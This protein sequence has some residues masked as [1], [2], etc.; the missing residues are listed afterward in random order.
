MET[1]QHE[2]QS[3]S[4]EHAGK[5]LTFKVAAEFYGIEILKVRE[6]IGIIRIT[7]VPRMPDYVKGVINLRGK[8]IPIIDLRLRFGLKPMEYTKRTCIVVV[9]VM[10]ENA[11]FQVGVIVDEVDEVL[12]FMPRQIEPA[13]DYGSHDK[14]EFIRA[15]GKVGEHVKI[16][17][18]IDKIVTQGDLSLLQEV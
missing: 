4:E 17:L 14:A 2:P 1:M 18:N 8:V 12:D 6:I 16:L 7:K 15:M 11:G 10:T 5:Y 13:P 3:W 9:E